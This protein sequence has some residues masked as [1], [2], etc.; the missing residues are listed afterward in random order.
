MEAGFDHPIPH[1]FWVDVRLHAESVDDAIS[2]AVAM[3][4]AI[5]PVIAFATNAEVGLIEPHLAFETTP[6]ASERSFVEYFVP[7]EYGLVPPSRDR[8]I[9]DSA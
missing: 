9:R 7:D 1:E 8:Y 4:N 6:G 2:Q 3:V 5:V